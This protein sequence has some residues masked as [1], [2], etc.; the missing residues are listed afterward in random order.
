[1][2]AVAEAVV[3]RYLHADFRARHPEAAERIRARLLRDEAASYAAC[4]EA[5]AGDC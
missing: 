2:A 1:M 4:C 5:V 3:E